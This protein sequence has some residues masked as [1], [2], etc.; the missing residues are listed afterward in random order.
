MVGTSVNQEKFLKNE[1][2]IVSGEAEY[3]DLKMVELRPANLPKFP[4]VE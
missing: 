3:Q 2:L 4:T 1:R